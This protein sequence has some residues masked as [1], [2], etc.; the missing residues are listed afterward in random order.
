MKTISVNDAAEQLEALADL[1][2]QGETI[3]ISKERRLLIL[4]EFQPIEPIP[5]RP[6]GYFDESYSEDE[7]LE[8]NMMAEH[9]VRELDS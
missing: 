1:A 7:I 6:I 2:L 9:S 8:S 3:L 5:I 4:Q